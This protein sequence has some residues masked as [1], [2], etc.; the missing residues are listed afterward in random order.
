MKMPS[1]GNAEALGEER[2][3]ALILDQ[4][5]QL[6]ISHSFFFQDGHLNWVLGVISS[7]LPASECG[8][9]FLYPLF[10]LC[11]FIY[12]SRASFHFF[13]LYFVALACMGAFLYFSLWVLVKA[14]LLGLPRGSSSV[15][16][17]LHT[18]ALFMRA[19]LIINCLGWVLAVNETVLAVNE[20]SPSIRNI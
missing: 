13:I 16:L 2:A 20:K 10:S 4:V 6:W 19:L 5:Y 12:L 17:Y 3:I 9:F 1:L 15:L 8:F 7:F 18:L 11:G 14:Y